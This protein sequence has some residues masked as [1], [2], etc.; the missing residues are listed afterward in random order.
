MTYKKDMTA[1]T[2]S[3]MN[4]SGIAHNS[5]IT[6]SGV[7]P[8]VYKVLKDG[9]EYTEFVSDGSDTNMIEISVDSSLSEFDVEIVLSK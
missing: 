9:K 5:V 4:K 7:L 8:G 3:L 2:F 1:Y 6:V